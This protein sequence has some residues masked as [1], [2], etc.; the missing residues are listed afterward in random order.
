MQVYAAVVSADPHTELAAHRAALW[1]SLLASPL[2]AAWDRLAE[3]CLGVLVSAG[4][5]LSRNGRVLSEAR[6]TGRR[7]VV[8]TIDAMGPLGRLGARP[9][10]VVACERP[11]TLDAEA[12]ADSGAVLVAWGE[13]AEDPALPP[14]TWRVRGQAGDGDET[15]AAH[16]L[17]RH[18]GCG[19]VVLAGVDLAFVDG[20]AHAPG[21]AL[22]RA[23]ALES[24]PFRSWDWMHARRI[25]MRKGGLFREPDRGGR[26]VLM[27][28]M[29]RRERAVLEAAFDEDRRAGRMVIDATEGGC[30]KRHTDQMPL[31]EAMQRHAS[32]RVPELQAAPWTAAS[33][34]AAIPGVQAMRSP[35]R[36][37]AVVP[38]DPERGG[39][40][41]E[42]S[43]ASGL[44]ERTVLRCTLERLLEARE[45]EQV[46][47]AVP[48]GWD[49][50]AALDGLPV[51]GRLRLMTRRG[52]TSP[53]QRRSRW[54]ARAWC[55]A[56]WRGGLGG[57][58]VFDEVLDAASVQ[59]ALEAADA[60]HAFLCGPDWP[61][62]A[63]REAWGADG[64]VRAARASP[65][66]RWMHFAPGAAGASGC[67]LSREAVASLVSGEVPSIGAWL[68]RRV[69]WSRQPERMRP[70][71]GVATLRERLIMDT[72]RA[73]LRLRRAVEPLLL[74]HSDPDQAMVVEAVSRVAEAAPTLPPQ[75]LI[76]E[77]NTGRRGCGLSSP[78]RFGSLQ[79][80][81]MTLRR[82]DRMTA[83]LAEA[84]DVVVTL[85]GAGDPLIHPD[86]ADMVR[87][88]RAAGAL[89]IELR[90]ELLSPTAV[91]R[92]RDLDVEVISVDLHAVDAPGYRV[93]M[94]PGDFGGACAALHD[95]LL[96]RQG[97]RTDPFP[98]LL[99]RVERLRASVAWVPMFVEVWTRDGDGAI[100]DPPPQ[101]DPWGAPLPH[102]PMA[103]T[104]DEAWAHAD[105]LRR[106]TV[107]SDGRVP[108]VDGDLLGSLSVGSVDTE[109]L[110]ALH[111]SL[112]SMRRDRGGRAGLALARMA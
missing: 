89:A 93:M 62:V 101:A 63:V 92:V 75:Q 53:L 108:V 40:G 1:Q 105:T 79:R 16:L 87:L 106:M 88:L 20:V 81:P 2:A 90:T 32:R 19:T 107:L 48:E 14:G 6:W 49:A 61:V 3:G 70:P 74:R 95:L 8:A 27:D 39:T 31:E 86:V 71:T 24:H 65:Q 84:K 11:R 68:E 55:D 37:I 85:G 38:V 28:T 110:V 18:L 59:M 102:A 72:P 42:R 64:M 36:A 46:V 4:P 26:T 66:P 96:Q 9:D 104:G 5:S 77:L 111:R 35:V 97:A 30:T 50:S 25:S 100:V 33:S 112:V 17:L 56:C 99:P 41:V 54:A 98:W 43:L 29:L 83:R 13:A 103:A 21:H 12:A 69:D 58:S 76:V 45:L 47:L 52:Q 73:I 23:W 15:F 80:P 78:H 82:M 91:E 94:G 51:Q 10:V 44:G 22:D 7:L 67:L 57:R 109:D 34:V 60:S